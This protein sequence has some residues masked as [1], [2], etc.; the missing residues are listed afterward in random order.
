LKNTQQQQIWI[1][2]DC[3]VYAQDWYRD[4]NKLELE[5]AE[6]IHT[7]LLKHNRKHLHQ[8][9]KTPISRGK[10]ADKTGKF[11]ENDICDNILE[12]QWIQDEQIEYCI[13]Q[14]IQE[15]RY[16]DKGVKDCVIADISDEDYKTFWK[17]K[18][19]SNATS[20]FGLHVGHYKTGIYNE[21]VLYVHKT[22]MLLPF[23]HGF[24]PKLWCKSIQLMLQKDIG[25]LWLHQLRIIE[26]L[27]ASFNAALM[28]IVGRTLIHTANDND[29]IHQSVY[30]LVSNRSTHGVQL[31]K[32]INIHRLL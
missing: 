21:Y 29:R 5:V 22:L 27:D 18:G 24:V 19:V 16:V 9:S 12:G 32:I 25:K 28:M 6:E 20:H 13:F 14:Y 8:A 15:L 4:N 1:C 11:G 30:G 2:K 17:T 26:I 31:S 23:K 7:Q 10:L 3:N